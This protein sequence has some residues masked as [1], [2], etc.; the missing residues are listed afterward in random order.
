M[1]EFCSLCSPFEFYEIDLKKMANG[2][3]NDEAQD[4]LC[5][6]CGFGTLWKDDQGRIFLSVKRQG[7]T[8]E[9]EVALED[10]T[11]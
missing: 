2:L 8:L 9:K 5:E 6:G 3:N 1:A 7:E 11:P 10:L 4:F